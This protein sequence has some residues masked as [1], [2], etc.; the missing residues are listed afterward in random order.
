MAVGE[1]VVPCVLHKYTGIMN[2]ML[3]VVQQIIFLAAAN[4]VSNSMHIEKDVL[5]GLA[6]SVGLLGGVSIEEA[7]LRPK[8]RFE[9][10]S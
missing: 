8:L 10:N 2:S 5:K 1:Y 3:L 9:K 7:Y 4:A 6:L